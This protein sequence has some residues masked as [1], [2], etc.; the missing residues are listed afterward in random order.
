MAD[1]SPDLIP[2]I[3]DI[4]REIQQTPFGDINLQVS[5]H[6]GVV[7]GLTVSSFRNELF[8]RD[9]DNSQAMERV[10]AIAKKMVEQEETG[11]LTFTLVFDKGKVRKVTHQFYDLK[12]YPEQS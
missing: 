9:G 4:V 3:T 1:F 6:R 2:V 8:G 10:I 5:T 11:T 7:S 12:R